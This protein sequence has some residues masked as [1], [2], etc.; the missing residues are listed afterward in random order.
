MGRMT[1][2]LLQRPELSTLLLLVLLQ[3]LVLEQ[4][5]G[6]VLE[7]VRELVLEQGQGPV[8]ARHN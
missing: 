2:M 6:L 3:E 1:V 4:V 8:L 7:R 5:L